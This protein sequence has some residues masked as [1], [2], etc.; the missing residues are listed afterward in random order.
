MIFSGTGARE[1]VEEADIHVN[2]KDLVDLT[3]LHYGSDT[4]GICTMSG[5]SDQ[6]IRM[7][8]YKKAVSR[9]EM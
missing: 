6:F 7:F 9:S 5:L 3:A 2:K 4:Y 8:L 1:L